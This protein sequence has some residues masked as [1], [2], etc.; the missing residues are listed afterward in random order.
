ME[1]VL[2]DLAYHVSIIGAAFVKLAYDPHADFGAGDIVPAAMDPRMVRLDPAVTRAYNIDQAQYV[3]I[4]TVEPLWN[5]WRQFPGRGSLVQAESGL[6]DIPKKKSETDGAFLRRVSQFWRK[7]SSVEADETTGDLRYPAGRHVIRGGDLVV[8]K[9][10]P[11]PYW[12]GQWDLEMLDGRPDPE[13]PWGRSEVEALR[14]IQESINR[15][16]NL[17]LENRIRLGYGWITADSDA[18]EPKVIEELRNAGSV[19]LRKRFG[20]TVVREA[21]PPMPPDFLQYIQLCLQLTDYLSGLTDGSMQGKGRVELRSGVQLEGLQQAAQVLVRFM[22]RRLESFLQRLGQKWISR[23]FQ[24]YTSNRILT[25]LG[26]GDAWKQFA[27]ERQSL[28]KEILEAAAKDAPALMAK[29]QISHEDA[30][31]R[32]LTEKLKHSWRDFRFKITPGSSLAATKVQRALLFSQLAQQGM[33]PREDV[34]T[35]LGIPD[36]KE[37]VA[38][39]KLEQLEMGPIPVPPKSKGAAKKP[40]GM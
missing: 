19:V 9:D 38:Q 13:H 20:R 18:L 33:I 26:P 2:E 4:E 5:L 39:A 24:F 16:G 32:L 31:K 11:N 22:A 1:Q 34:L 17:Y 29:E 23:V 12:D 7:K 27:F 14:R 8:L 10:E 40:G 30:L 15:I 37:K 35:E 28:V 21:P 36:P 6:T 25:F 3:R